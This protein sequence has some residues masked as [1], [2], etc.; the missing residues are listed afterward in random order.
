MTLSS[1]EADVADPKHFLQQFN[2]LE[3]LETITLSMECYVSDDSSY[4]QDG[5]NTVVNPAPEGL[6]QSVNENCLLMR[7][8]SDTQ[9][10][11][12]RGAK[13]TND[14]Y[15]WLETRYVDRIAKD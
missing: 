8:M 13:D 4:I 11:A 15:P 10:Y 7:E 6:P 14:D 9:A 3:R 12:L 2:Y 5:E 1:W